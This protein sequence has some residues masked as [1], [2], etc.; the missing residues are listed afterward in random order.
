MSR[1]DIPAL[2]SEHLRR[3]DPGVH[4][5][6][7]VRQTVQAAE[8]DADAALFQERGH[9]SSGQRAVLHVQGGRHEEESH[10]RGSREGSVDP[11]SN[12][13][14]GG[15]SAVLSIRAQGMQTTFSLNLSRLS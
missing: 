3:H 5:G 15:E 12:Y 7:G 13:G 11:A 14:R 10:H 2:S 4:G 8:E 9:M 1:G 6:S